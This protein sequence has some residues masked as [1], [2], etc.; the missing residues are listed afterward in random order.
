MSVDKLSAI[1]KSTSSSATATTWPVPSARE[2]V[3]VTALL[4]VNTIDWSSLIFRAFSLSGLLVRRYFAILSPLR[5]VV[6]TPAAALARSAGVLSRQRAIVVGY[7]RHGGGTLGRLRLKRCGTR[8]LHSLI[9]VDG[10]QLLLDRWRS[11]TA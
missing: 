4:G 2:R 1:G 6:V 3:V 10:R 8:P 9:S 5:A 7:F 11:S